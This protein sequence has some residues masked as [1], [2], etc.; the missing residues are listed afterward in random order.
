MK[1]FIIQ[2]REAFIR[3]QM[4]SCLSPQLEGELLE[5]RACANLLTTMLPGLSRGLSK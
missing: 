1:V 4:S 5:G 3:W 2:V